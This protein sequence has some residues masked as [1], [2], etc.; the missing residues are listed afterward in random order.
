M[1][2][3]V[4]FL[5]VMLTILAFRSGPRRLSLRERS[6]NAWSR[7]LPRSPLTMDQLVRR[8]LKA[9]TETV[10]IGVSGQ[11][12]LASEIEVLVNPADVAESCGA[13]SLI[14][15]DVTAALAH[16]AARH[17]WKIPGGQISVRVS[18]DPSRAIGVPLAVPRWAPGEYDRVTNSRYLA[19]K[20]PHHSARRDGFLETT[21][22]ETMPVKEAALTKSPDRSVSLVR[23]DRRSDDQTVLTFQL[24]S[25]PLDVG[26]DRQVEI[27]LT[28][29]SVSRRHC[30]FRMVDGV[31]TVEDLGS[32][33]GTFIDGKRLNLPEPLIDTSTIEIGLTTWMVVLETTRGSASLPCSRVGPQ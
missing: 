2:I 9:A 25:D 15:E 1:G 32:K 29:Q 10:W 21:V 4:C 17:H 31:V 20:N 6:I 19:A 7:Y 8:L 22:I 23:K 11:P 27:R 26:R 3:V 30:R 5:M 13:L 18:I 14:E 28:D 16:T 33:N 12:V 24:G